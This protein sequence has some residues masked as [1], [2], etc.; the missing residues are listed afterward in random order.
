VVAGLRALT[1]PTAISWAASLGWLDLSGTWLALFG[2]PWAPW[3]LTPLAL[4]ELANDK[5]PST[6][7][8]TV[9]PQF[10][11]RILTGGLSG[12]A[13]GAAAG[14][15]AAGLVA[16]VIGAVVG[17]LGGRAIRARLAST[18]KQD[19]PAA[20]IEDATAVVSAWL[21]VASRS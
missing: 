11:G 1:A 5:L 2:H 21:I 20:L 6:P 12:A 18:F 7:S 8:R 3:I 17:T 15:P 13:I 19:L 14:T 16:G 9:P 10:V 4:A